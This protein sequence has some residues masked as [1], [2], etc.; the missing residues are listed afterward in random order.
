[1]NQNEMIAYLIIGVVVIGII[2]FVVMKMS[3][4]S[5]SGDGSG[6]GSGDGSGSGS[7]SGTDSP[8]TTPAGFATATTA[9]VVASTP[10][11]P[12]GTQPGTQGGVYSAGFTNVYLQN[13]QYIG[14]P[15][16]I[17][18]TNGVA[19]LAFYNGQLAINYK[20][21]N[22]PVNGYPANNYSGYVAAM[23]P[24]GG[25]AYS[26]VVY[27]NVGE[28]IFMTS[29]TDFINP[30]V[31]ITPFIKDGNTYQAVFITNG[32]TSQIVEGTYASLVGQVPV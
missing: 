5:G 27:N 21:V 24:Q 9:A 30:V 32:G 8:S 3:S 26:L 10:F 20:G 6:S 23:M 22:T 31:A 4:G 17:F 1:M 13:G 14:G 15:Q 12:S 25:S 29:A 16:G 28:Q 2:I 11:I 7:G 18:I 19:T